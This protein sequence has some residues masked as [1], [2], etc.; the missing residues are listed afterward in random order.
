MRTSRLPGARV[1]SSVP[2][3][4]LSG[5][6][7]YVQARVAGIHQHVNGNHLGL[8]LRWLLRPALPAAVLETSTGPFHIELLS[9]EGLA[10]LMRCFG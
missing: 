1:L 6:L 2:L 10:K 3:L 5:R 4:T 7:F 9:H 8:D